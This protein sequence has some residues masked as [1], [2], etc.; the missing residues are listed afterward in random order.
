MKDRRV[1]DIF[2]SANITLCTTFA[3][4]NKNV[5]ETPKGSDKTFYEFFLNNAVAFSVI[6]F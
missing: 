4:N 6:D 2:V 5:V 1:S 3:G